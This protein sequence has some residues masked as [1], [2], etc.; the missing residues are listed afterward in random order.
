MKSHIDTGIN[1]SS[2]SIFVFILI[3]FH[4]C[5]VSSPVS[6]LHRYFP[7]GKK[8]IDDYLH[9][10]PDDCKK[11]LSELTFPL[12]IPFQISNDS[13]IL[14]ILRLIGKEFNPENKN[15][16]KVYTLLIDF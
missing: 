13:F 3:L 8:Y 14:D 11:F 1:A 15:S 7:I 16:S 12:N 10:A 2:K 4:P 6:Y 5:K 9:F